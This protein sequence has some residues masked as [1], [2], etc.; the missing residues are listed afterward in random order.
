MEDLLEKRC[1]AH[2]PIWYKHCQLHRGEHKSSTEDR[3]Q[4]LQ[5]HAS[6]STLYSKCHIERRDWIIINEKTHHQ[7]QIQLHYQHKHRKKSDP[8][9]H[10]ERDRNG[11]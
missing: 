2:N 11:W 7:E 4:C 8:R 9:T 10:T 3:E 1:T 5:D 6:S